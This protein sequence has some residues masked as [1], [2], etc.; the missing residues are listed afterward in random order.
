MHQKRNLHRYH[1]LKC[2][3][4]EARGGRSRHEIYLEVQKDRTTSIAGDTAIQGHDEDRPVH[5]CSTLMDNADVDM[6]LA[7]IRKI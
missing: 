5:H 1:T 6:V 4:A 3:S 2:P 7:R